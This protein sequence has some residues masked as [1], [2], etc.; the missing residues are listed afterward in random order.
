M[1]YRELGRDGPRVPVL[2]FGAWPLG[3][4]MGDIDEGTAIATVRAAIDAGITLID[5]AQGYRTSE[6]TLGKALRDGY[7]QKCFL[8]TKVS[9]DYSAKGIR[10]AIENS[11]RNLDVEFVDLYQ[12]HGWSEEYPVEESIATLAELQREGKTRHI[13]VSNY[14]AE[15]MRRA[16]GTARFQS[17]Q[18]RYNM[19]DRRIEAEDIPFCEREGIGLLTHSALAKGLLT[20]KYYPGHKFAEGDERSG[21]PQFQGETFAGYLAAAEELREVAR[22]K[23]LTLVQMAIAWLLRLPAVSC[24][25]VGA[26]NPEQ[27]KE[28][29]G[30]LGVAF[31]A[32]ELAR[33]DAILAAAP[34]PEA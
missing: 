3:G 28:H 33:I 19:F 32:Q 20:G 13:G 14:N 21:F 12:I 23:D 29:L 8:A 18:P 4:G 7:R 2:G 17:C 22:G 24:V 5:T 25:L 27:V 6:A 26:R 10:A 34:R 31:D 9:G 15:R 11:L 1:E 16:L 30:A